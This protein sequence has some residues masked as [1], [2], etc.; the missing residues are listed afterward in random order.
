MSPLVFH[1]PF[2]L[3]PGEA[4]ERAGEDEGLAGEPP[5]DLL[6]LHGRL[7]PGI[8]H[9]LDHPQVLPVMEESEDALADLGPDLADGEEFGLACLFQVVDA[10]EGACQEPRGMFPD[11]ADA[12]GVDEA[13]ELPLL[14]SSRWQ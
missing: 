11:V 3:V 13:G 7:D 2:R 8:E 9:A 10:A 12:E 5:A 1:E 14:C 4:G 6:L